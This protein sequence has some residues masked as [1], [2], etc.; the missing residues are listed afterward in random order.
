M[1]VAGASFVG[2]GA[3]GGGGALCAEGGAKLNIT[4]CA[5]R[6]NRAVVGGAVYGTGEN[7]SLDMEFCSSYGNQATKEGGALRALDL[8]HF[9]VE[10]CV[11]MGYFHVSCFVFGGGVGGVRR[12]NGGDA[13][14]RV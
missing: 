11:E 9:N 6:E 3:S 5:F 7:T 13:S 12:P 8:G 4:R 14:E 2:N 10:R 1:T